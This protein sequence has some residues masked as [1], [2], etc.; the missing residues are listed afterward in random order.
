MWGWEGKL[1]GFD[2]R[3]NHPGRLFVDTCYVGPAA[4]ELQYLN[5]V[6]EKAL[7]ESAGL[8][9]PT[10]EAE[11]QFLAEKGLDSIGGATIL[12]I[13]SKTV[14]SSLDKNL[15]LEI[16]AEKGIEVPKFGIVGISV[17]D[18]FP[19]IVKPRSGRGSRQ[20][21]RFDTIEEFARLAP[22][23]FVW[24]SFLSPESEEY[25]CAIYRSRLRRTR[26]LLMRRTLI[27][28]STGI[29]EVVENEAI[30]GY[31]TAIANSLD[32]WG[33]LNVQLRLTSQGPLV[34][35][36]NPRLSSTL[37]FRDKMGFFDFRWWVQEVLGV[38]AT[39][40]VPNTLGPKVG[41]LFYRGTAEYFEPMPAE[42]IEVEYRD[43]VAE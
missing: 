1:S 31:I 17:P 43:H 40:A 25:T 39:P 26:V 13:D 11:I 7:E 34:F 36:I 27:G 3:P 21:S 5:W 32:F 20:V 28:G 6:E 23:G 41:T 19:V 9:I 33:A 35:E 4:K 16:L 29:G 37:V 22:E 10:S 18:E 30:R 2:V 8:F 42:A 15:C 38:A 12:R 14:L 24:Q